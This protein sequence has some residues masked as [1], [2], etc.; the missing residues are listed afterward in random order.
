MYHDIQDLSCRLCIVLD[1][2]GYGEQQRNDRKMLYET[3]DDMSK[4]SGRNAIDQITVGSKGEG[5]T[6]IFES[7]QDQLLVEQTSICCA[8]YRYRDPKGKN[9]FVMENAYSSPGHAILTPGEY[10]FQISHIVGESIIELDIGRL[11]SS[12][13]FSMKVDEVI[14]KSVSVSGDDGLSILSRSGPASRLV[15]GSMYCDKVFA[16]ECHCPDIQEA[17]ASRPRRYD[18]PSLSVIHEVSGMKAYAVATGCE[19]SVYEEHEWRICFNTGE[20]RLIE[21]LTDVQIK[22][23]VLMK[24]LIKEKGIFRSNKLTSF[25]MKNIVF[26][27][28]E[29]N[30]QALF[31][32]Q[33]L[34][35][36][37]LNAFRI[38][39]KSLKLKMLPYYMMSERNLFKGKL[40][41]NARLQIIKDIK[42]VLRDGP[43]TL[44]K[45]E[46]LQR[47]LYCFEI[48][49]SLLFDLAEKRNKAELLIIQLQTTN[50]TGVCI[51]S[52]LF[53]EDVPGPN[54][55]EEERLMKQLN[56][57]IWPGW[58]RHAAI[59][60]YCD[61]IFW[62]YI[63]EIFR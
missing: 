25:M 42:R 44:P 13:V 18:W 33:S 8:D 32:E 41:K 28:A 12:S 58:R 2:L 60:A 10:L 61:R 15:K 35:Q 23:Y 20:N 63:E 26:W 39:L 38:L 55:C 46:R 22:V 45:V 47:C 43:K 48:A 57:L 27:M 3:L 50:K 36:W 16:L 14:E 53:G 4:M 29:L 7:D 51:R 11:L 21:S 40:D 19:G 24:M 17:W 30:P 5:I 62:R 6:N 31:T 59:G 52:T 49:P 54:A 56:D 9:V 1:C 37:V 34:V